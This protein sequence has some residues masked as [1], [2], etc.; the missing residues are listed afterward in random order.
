MDVLFFLF[1]FFFFIIVL[2]IIF[3]LL[4]VIRLLWKLNDGELD[5]AAFLVVQ[6]VSDQIIIFY[7]IE[8][9]S[10][11]LIKQNICMITHYPMSFVSIQFK[12]LVVIKFIPSFLI[13]GNGGVMPAIQRA[14][15]KHDRK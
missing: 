12:H 2:I 8:I 14:H 15:V 13:L 10:S 3:L 9:Y 1:F 5:A 4:F 6:S 7:V 11:F